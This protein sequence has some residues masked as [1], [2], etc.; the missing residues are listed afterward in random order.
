MDF[1][2]VDAFEESVPAGRVDDT[3]GQDFDDEA[4]SSA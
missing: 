3:D 4:W 1:A 2:I